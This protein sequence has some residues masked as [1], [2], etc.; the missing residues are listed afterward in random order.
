LDALLPRG[1]LLVLL[2]MAI[3][4]TLWVLVAAADG[5]LWRW[6]RH[7]ARRWRTSYRARLILTLFGFFV[8]PALAFA[9]WSYNRLNK[10]DGE[11]RTLVVQEA[12]RTI[13]AQPEL[14]LEE[15][16]ER[17]G[18]PLLR[19]R[20]GELKAASDSL[21]ILLAPLG[22]TLPPRA[23]LALGEEGEAA[24]TLP[25]TASGQGVLVGFRAYS[26]AGGAAVL[27]APLRL[28]DWVLDR[29]RRD[30][31]MLVAFV[32][33]LGA[34]AAL[35]LSGLAARELERP[36]GMLRQAALRVAGGRRMEGLGRAPAA[37]F[38]PVFD[39][40]QKMEHELWAGRRALEE[41]RLRTEAVLRRV[42]S[43]VA[44]FEESGR[45]ILAN[46]RMERIAG[47]ELPTGSTAASL[48]VAALVQR[49][50][51]F[52]AGTVEEEVF[53][54][55]V[56]RRHLR[57]NL[58]R[59]EQ[60][61]VVVTLDDVTEV[62]RAERILA[63]GEM[64]RQVAHEVKNPL[65]PIRLGVQHLLRAR[66]DPR[67][68]FDSLLEVNATRILKEIDRLDE[69]ARAFSRYGMVP[70]EQA[71]AIGVNI[72]AVVNDVVD[73]ERL[74]GSEVEWRFIAGE[75]EVQ[76]MAREGDLREVLVNVL[77]N[78]LSRVF[79]PRFSTKSSGSGLGLAISRALLS[80]WGGSIEISNRPGGGA[81]VRIALP[82]ARP[83]NQLS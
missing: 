10:A 53:D 27:A 76:V 79:E 49:I 24:V 59:S 47:R 12:L 36:V 62:A 17:F 71:V 81:E 64:A 28:G 18:L 31:T 44:A 40:F 65:T 51:G 21:Y 74:G 42:A 41:A 8:V 77:E 34:L 37:E 73:L 69:I 54:L 70:L 35:I 20:R 15:L 29:E 82:V 78:A 46:P 4:G 48:G 19:Y 52:L 68:N 66:R 60:G 14:S 38:A 72:A 16:G 43:G 11:T 1:A 67:V 50:E 58:L 5:A 61:G 22:R 26:D 30:I 45:L 2:D 63:W 25:T 7:R 32:T 55:E 75:D 56:N 23:A 83:D 80:S 13:V 57:G 33:I 6:V 9:S 3:M 39:A